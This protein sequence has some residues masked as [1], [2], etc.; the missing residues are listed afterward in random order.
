[1]RGVPK[2]LL[3]AKA[4]NIFIKPLKDRSENIIKLWT[5][6]KIF[7]GRMGSYFDT[8]LVSCRPVRVHLCPACAERTAATGSLSQTVA[9]EG[10]AAVP[11]ADPEASECGHNKN[12]RLPSTDTRLLSP[13]SKLA[14]HTKGLLLASLPFVFDWNAERISNEVIQEQL[15]AIDYVHRLH[16]Q[17]LFCGDCHLRRT[18]DRRVDG[19]SYCSCRQGSGRATKVMDQWEPY[20]ERD[21]III[22]RRPQG[23]GQFAYKVYGRYEDVTAE[24]FF[25][26]QT[27]VE[28]RKVWDKS[29]LTLDIV[30][31]DQENGSNCSVIYWELLWPVSD[32]ID[33]VI[34]YD[35][36]WE[37]ER[38]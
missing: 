37:F 32:N 18:I 1:M 34:C 11:D 4:R 12:P 27:D 30:D 29:A 9:G 2:H 28:Y 8:V 16:E 14:G 33:Y 35:C 6:V 25:F 5:G 19:I 36:V 17:T 3:I 21:N 26:V 13:P 22:W 31:T 7:C 24:D 15:Q 10:P 38:S 20:L 23:G